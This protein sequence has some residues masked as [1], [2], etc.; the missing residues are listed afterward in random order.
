MVVERERMRQHTAAVS[1]AVARDGNLLYAKGYGDADPALH[2][3]AEPQTIYAIGSVTKQFTAAL[4]MQLVEQG[5][6]KLDAKLADY[7]PDAPHAREITVRYLLDQRSGLPDYLGDP[8]VLRY[9]YRQDV[10]PDQLVALV[11]SQRLQFTPGSKWAYSNTNYVL[12]GML[13]EK[14]AG[15]PY[16]ELLKLNILRPQQLTSTT[17]SIPPASPAVAIGMSWNEDKHARES[18]PRW[19]S[20]VAYAAGTMNSNVLDLTAWDT[21]FFGGRVVS[22]ASVREMTTAPILAD[23]RSDG[24]GFGWILGKVYGRNEVWHNGGIPGFAARNAYFPAERVSVVVLANDINFDATLIVREALAAAVDMSAAE[25]AAYD[26]P[27]PAPGEDARITALARAQ[28]E[29]L[30]AGAIDKG[31]YT[32][33]MIDAMTPA[34][35][36]QVQT[37]L[38]ALGP[39]TLITFISK[40]PGAGVDTYVYKVDCAQ[41]SVRETMALDGSGKIAGLFVKPWDS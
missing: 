31:A 24:Y 26:H 8:F 22:A 30:R 17:P 41:G 37:F 18:V 2:V 23:G 7:L 33:T 21:A 32:Q 16:D 38:A 10:T 15:A 12:L 11:A 3:A 6:V 39:Q 28:F 4:V 20:Q 13:I 9:V 40:T 29:A 5:R 19:S 27:A 36:A 34:V 25:R 35:I 1:L 14:V